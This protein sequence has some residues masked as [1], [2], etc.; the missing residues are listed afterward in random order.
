VFLVTTRVFQGLLDEVYLYDRALSAS[1]IAALANLSPPSTCEADLTQCEADLTECL[2]NPVISDQDGDGEPDA[3]DGCPNTPADTDVDQ[4]GGS[5]AQFC[6]AIDATTPQGAKVCEKSDW[7]NDEPLMKAREA[8]CQV[9]K[10]TPGRG[11]D[12]CVPGVSD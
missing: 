3:T 8:D 12:R 10:G 9:A 7:Q 11:D 2:T 1:E 6:T 5:L 4:A